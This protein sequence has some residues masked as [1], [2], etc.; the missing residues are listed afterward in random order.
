MSSL[1]KA[2]PVGC[3]VQTISREVLLPPS[4]RM[5]LYHPMPIGDRFDS[6]PNPKN[7]NGPSLPHCREALMDA[8]VLINDTISTGCNAS[9]YFL[10]FNAIVS[11]LWG[12][13]L[14][15]FSTGY[16]PITWT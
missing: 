8:G 6:I 9:L 13:A 15:V 12:A 16:V 5:S 14:A 10:L 3:G 4:P 7:L 11:L 1:N 2:I